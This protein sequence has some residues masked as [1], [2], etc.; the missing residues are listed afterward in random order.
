MDRGTNLIKNH[1]VNDLTRPFQHHMTIEDKLVTSKKKI[2]LLICL[3][4][5]LKKNLGFIKIPQKFRL[6]PK[7]FEIP[8]KAHFWGKI[9][10]VGNPAD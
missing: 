10:A 5:Y 2:K 4:L 8:Q 1:H 3:F 6:L 7:G 9:R